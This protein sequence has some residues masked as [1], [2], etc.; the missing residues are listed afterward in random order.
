MPQ[1]KKENGAVQS[2]VMSRG[3]LTVPVSL[4]D[5]L[6]MLTALIGDYAMNTKLFNDVED[7]FR[8]ASPSMYAYY[9]YV[10]LGCHIKKYGTLGGPDASIIPI[11]CEGLNVPAPVAK[12]LEHLGPFVRDGL[13]LRSKLTFPTGLAIGSS[14][15]GKNAPL[16]NQVWPPSAPQQTFEHYEIDVT[17]GTSAFLNYSV[18]SGNPNLGLAGFVQDWMEN[19]SE[20]IQST[21]LSCI[22]FEKIPKVAPDGSAYALAY[23]EMTQTFVQPAVNPVNAQGQWASL[24]D[25]F[26]PEVA[27][28]FGSYR[29]INVDDTFPFTSHKVPIPEMNRAPAADFTN[30][31]PMFDNEFCAHYTANYLLN[32]TPYVKGSLL[33]TLKYC[34]RPVTTLNPSWR[35][36]NAAVFAQMIYAAYQNLIDNSNNPGTGDPSSTFLVI[37]YI[38]HW[39]A[40]IA[41]YNR[42]TPIHNYQAN[43]AGALQ[44]PQAWWASSEWLGLDFPAPCAMYIDS[45]GPTLRDGRM[46]FPVYY[47][48]PATGTTD[49]FPPEVPIAYLPGFLAEA[50]AA[51]VTGTSQAWLGFHGLS[52]K[53]GVLPATFLSFNDV[54]LNSAWVN[55]AWGPTNAKISTRNFIPNTWI[56]EI[57]SYWK[58]AHAMFFRGATMQSCLVH[59]HEDPCGSVA[60]MYALPIDGG[61]VFNTVVFPQNDQISTWASTSGGFVFS[62]GQGCTKIISDVNLT[63]DKFVECAA[64]A[65]TLF[66]ASDA[67][68]R[69]TF[70]LNVTRNRNVLLKDLFIQ[71]YSPDSQFS[72]AISTNLSNFKPVVENAGGVKITSLDLDS[73][74]FISDTLDDI[75]RLAFKG[76]MNAAPLLCPLTGPLSG[77][78]SMGAKLAVDT[79]KSYSG[80]VAGDVKT[81][82]VRGVKQDLIKMMPSLANE[83]GV[84][85]KQKKNGTVKS[86]QVPLPGGKTAKVRLTPKKVRT[87]E[88]AAARKIAKKARRQAK[89]LA[90]KK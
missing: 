81:P 21:N 30:A 9:C 17:G 70:T 18:V 28:I 7:G 59:L 25:D 53:A 42:S 31:A 79:I 46:S 45:V 64:V 49:G 58:Q 60:A 48:A 13:E 11:D 12:F 19:I 69:Y 20:R 3:V 56:T 54:D 87:P 5:F 22:K 26:D 55:N 73:Q 37:F 65:S 15:W 77:V 29:T 38:V 1:T 32:R 86:V 52:P 57:F 44:R 39:C 24:T 36:Y 84:R 82:D 71:T 78:C 34:E 72:R 16:I 2:G 76:V 80:I 33:K 62:F 35:F 40:L 90:A 6:V 27:L 8:L 89:K 41:K 67:I 43:G 4:N 85:V 66:P 75:K 23:D 74:C 50:D 63:P 68:G 88:Q 51:L 10:L 61:A 47:A 14:A 83:F